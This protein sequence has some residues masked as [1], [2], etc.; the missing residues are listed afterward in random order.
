M[1]SIIKYLHRRGYICICMCIYGKERIDGKRKLE[2]KMEK[3]IKK[4]SLAVGR[5]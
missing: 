3:E 1:S 5:G 4:S 2:K